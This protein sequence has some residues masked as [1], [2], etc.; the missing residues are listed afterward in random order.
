V[1]TE[2]A[3]VNNTAE[4]TSYTYDYGT[5]AKLTTV[6]PN[7]ATCY[8]ATPP[9]APN[10]GNQ[11]KQTV[12]D[13]LGRPLQ[14]WDSFTN[15]GSLYTLYETESFA[16]TDGPQAKVNHSHF[17]TAPGSNAVIVSVPDETDFDGHG[18][19]IRKVRFSNGGAAADAVTTFTYAND[20]TLA[21]VSLPD[22]T[23]NDTSTVT[24]TYGFD[25]LGRPTS[26]RRPDSTTPASQSGA[27]ISYNGV[28]TTTIEAVGTASG[29]AASTVTTKDSFGRLIEVAEQVDSGATWA[30]TNY[31][32][33]PDDNVFTVIDPDGVT[34]QLTHDFAGHR[35]Q[36][37]R[38]GRTWKYCYDLNGNVIAEQ[39]PGSPSPPTTDI[40][41]TNTIAYDDLDRPLS[42]VIG[43]RALSTSD[44][45]LF[46]NATEVYQWDTGTSHI[47]L[48]GQIRTWRTFAPGAGS[49]DPTIYIQRYYDAQANPV[50]TQPRLQ[51]AGLPTL[52]RQDHRTYFIDGVL[53]SVEFGDANGGSNNTDVDFIR[54]QRGDVQWARLLRTGVP[55]LTI[56]TQTRNVAGLVTKRHTTLTGEPI[57]YVESNW[58]Y[59]KLGRVGS[60][61]VQTSAGHVAEQDLAYFGN[62]DPKTLDHYLG[63]NHKQFSYG[64]DWRH[65]LTTA[66]ENTTTGYFSATYTF[67]TAGRFSHATETS[68]LPTGSD[69]KPRD[70]S[71][72]YAGTDP[73]EVTALVN[74]SGSNNGLPFASYAYDAAGNQISRCY[75]TVASPCNGDELD[76]VYDGKDQLRRATHKNNGST[77]GSEEY[78]Y[79]AYG[80]RIATVKR[81]SGGNKTELI[82]WIGDT[83]AHYDG[84]GALEHVYSYVT[85]GTPVARVDRT[86]NTTTNLEFEFHG[87]ASSTLAAVDQS[88]TINASFDTAPFGEIIETTD[89]SGGEGVPAHRRRLNDK[90]FDEV[91]DLGYYGARYYD[92]T[93]MSWTQG[94][95][96]YR[97]APDAAS[98]MPRRASLYMSDM[99]NPL[100]YR[101]PDGR[102]SQVLPWVAKITLGFLVDPLL[103]IALGSI[104]FEGG[105]QAATGI[106]RHG[107]LTDPAE[108]MTGLSSD[109]E[110]RFSSVVQEQAPM[111]ASKVD[112]PPGGGQGTPPQTATPSGPDGPEDDDFL[113]P[114]RDLLKGKGVSTLSR[115]GLPPGTGLSM[116]ELLGK[117][118][119]ELG[120]M[121]KDPNLSAAARKAI[122]RVIKMAKQSPRILGKGG[123]LSGAPAPASDEHHVTPF[124]CGMDCEPSKF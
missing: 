113:K 78:W 112:R 102:N 89:S 29:N 93:S 109:V 17:I 84:T 21:N 73:E 24:Y 68:S 77:L 114:I 50:T 44:Q 37:A 85:M 64:Y 38:A 26:I 14:Q 121:L 116:A 83:E 123:D 65:Q 110:A 7:V 5:G 108:N 61:V 106:D 27:N 67:G 6:G 60:Q 2:A 115:R 40:N 30:T 32:Y 82:W 20:G 15:D 59:D 58:T 31:T 13:G 118:I 95:P 54:D 51:I 33:G 81:D 52:S 39:V 12:I 45:A 86:G 9:C 103:G 96:L 124:G 4:V 36:I 122:E 69:V 62:D 91:S 49:N 75:G 107:V 25:S 35:T 10:Q 98:V 34:T 120:E 90:F 117:S 92:K 42:K 111:Q 72:T 41:Y 87:L 1:T 28:T 63:S 101:D 70:V 43:P 23:A 97:F 100:R 18:R 74:T 119:S 66:T 57:S 104:A 53:V 79:D 3:G 80:K 22:P 48:D 19:P 46:G 47:G 88:G 99:N 56:G 55:S 16:Y 105:D 8:L 76:F 11:T 71:Y 94:D